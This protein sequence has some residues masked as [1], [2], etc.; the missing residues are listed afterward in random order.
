MAV[1][2][3][4]GTSHQAGDYAGFTVEEVRR[5]L[6]VNTQMATQLNI[7]QDKVMSAV[8]FYNGLQLTDAQEKE[9]RLKDGDKLE[10]SKEHTKAKPVCV[11]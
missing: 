11:S 7:P 10:F 6:L 2:L 5:D 3:I 1:T 8:A 9:N 4:F